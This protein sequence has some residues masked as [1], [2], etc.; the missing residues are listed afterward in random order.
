MSPDS[1]VIAPLARQAYSE[2]MFCGHNP[3]CPLSPTNTRLALKFGPR[4][5][6]FED[7]RALFSASMEV[8]DT[9]TMQHLESI[10]L[11]SVGGSL[12]WV[13]RR[14]GWWYACFAQ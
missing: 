3:R 13:D 4:G 8:F 1:L 12:T 9:K 14:D 10:D 5:L 7:I 6:V 2:N 11:T